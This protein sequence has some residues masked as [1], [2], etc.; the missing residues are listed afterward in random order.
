MH[1]FVKNY[2]STCRIRR[3]FMGWEW[4]YMTLILN[5]GRQRQVDLYYFK[6]I[7]VFKV[8]SRTARMT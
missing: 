2:E 8:S 3:T 1:D 6:A 7:L 4:W 5:I